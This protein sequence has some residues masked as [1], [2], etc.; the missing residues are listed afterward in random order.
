MREVKT[1]NASTTKLCAKA[2]HYIEGVR[3]EAKNLDLNTLPI[4]FDHKVN[5]F[6]CLST[7]RALIFNHTMKTRF[8]EKP[9]LTRETSPDRD[10]KA[11]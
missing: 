1:R 5:I 10:Q 11:S 8:L 4:E 3:I 7:K 2:I 9:L 6:L